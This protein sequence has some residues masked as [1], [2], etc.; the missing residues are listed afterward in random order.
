MAKIHNNTNHPLNFHSHNILI[1]PMGT[2]TIKDSLWRKLK[3]NKGVQ[4]LIENESIKVIV[5]EA[6][7]LMEKIIKFFY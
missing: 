6:P 3:K 5:P 2:Q 7:K 1:S 4:K